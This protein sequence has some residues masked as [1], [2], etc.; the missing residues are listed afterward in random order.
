[1]LCVVLE[2]LGI[3]TASVGIVSALTILLQMS[4]NGKPKLKLVKNTAIA[5]NKD[6]NL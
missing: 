6:K 5:I 4:I 3:H 2:S 1:M